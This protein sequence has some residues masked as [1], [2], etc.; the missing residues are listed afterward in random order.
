MLTKK[1]HCFI[2]KSKRN[3]IYYL[4]LAMHCKGVVQGS[5]MS[6]TPALGTSYY[7]SLDR[8]H[9]TRTISLSLPGVNVLMNSPS[10]ASATKDDKTVTQLKN[11]LARD[12]QFGKFSI[13]NFDVKGC[14][15][16]E[17]FGITDRTL[18]LLIATGS[19]RYNTPKKVRK[20]VA[21][22]RRFGFTET[23]YAL[24]DST[25]KYTA[26]PLPTCMTKSARVVKLDEVHLAAIASHLTRR[27]QEQKKKTNALREAELRKRLKANIARMSYMQSTHTQVSL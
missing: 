14:T 21:K 15:P 5:P 24:S 18:P 17:W 8:T 4:Y 11:I 3:R 16:F 7:N 26:C 6:Q 13:V 23:I 2:N 22:L 9:L 12:K 27:K 19:K 20:L 1:V 25:I 10:T